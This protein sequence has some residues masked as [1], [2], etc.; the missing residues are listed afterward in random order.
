MWTG[1]EVLLF[2][3]EQVACPPNADCAPPDEPA[4]QDGAA[5]NP[6]TA[7]WRRIT[8][9][10]VPVRYANTAVIA[11]S[12]YVWA[13]S[14]YDAEASPMFMRYSVTD[15]AWTSLPQPTA[16]GQGGPRRSAG[17]S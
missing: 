2:G 9:A 3:G 15:D 13:H 6:A 1:D 4:L 12:V 17:W 8:P 10:L 11:D 14:S 5:Y 7:T 16:D